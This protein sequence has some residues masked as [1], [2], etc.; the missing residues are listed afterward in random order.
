M[1][2]DGLQ[3]LGPHVG[4]DPPVAEACPVVAATV[5]PAVVED[6]T[7]GSDFRA[8]SCQVGEPV[9]V[10]VEVDGLPRVERY[11]ARSVRVLWP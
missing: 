1:V 8:C 11:R 3:A 10:V 5:E 4:V 9:L 2:D 7:F 6:E